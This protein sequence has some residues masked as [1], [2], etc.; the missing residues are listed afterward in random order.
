MKLIREPRKVLKGN[1]TRYWFDGCNLS[2]GKADMEAYA[3]S[4]CQQ[5]DDLQAVGNYH[6]RPSSSCLK[7]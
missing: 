7:K 5:F 4:Q 1:R 6:N 2:T 3:P